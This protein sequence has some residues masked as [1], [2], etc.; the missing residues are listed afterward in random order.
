MRVRWTP[1]AADDLAQIVEHI[2][3]DNREAARRVAKAIVEGIDGLKDFPRRGRAGRVENTREIVFLPWPYIA[4]YEIV[5]DQIRVLRIRH[6]A[7]NWP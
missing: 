1:T 5:Q 3:R 2:T 4:V 6:A 7:Q